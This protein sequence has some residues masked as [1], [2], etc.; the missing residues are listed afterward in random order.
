MVAAVLGQL[1]VLL[2]TA[3]LVAIGVRLAP[4][5]VGGVVRNHE[6]REYLA[7]FGPLAEFLTW[8]AFVA[9]A[10]M[11]LWTRKADDG[12]HVVVALL[13]ALLVLMFAGAWRVFR[14]YLAG[15]VLRTEAAWQVGDLIRV[16]EEEGTV[17]HL[18]HRTLQLQRPDGDLV[19]VPW[20]RISSDLLVRRHAEGDVVR[21]TFVVDCPENR[22]P[23]EVALRVEETVLLNHWCSAGHEP[24][25]KV[26]ADGSIQ[27]TVH[28]LT[29]ARIP[30]VEASVRSSLQ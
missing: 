21:H 11:W 9:G 7:R 25:I 17:A 1:M 24:A 14:D 23:S 28:A 3:V 5:L 22:S 6:R 16:G 29:E 19:H 15:V 26:R 4:L 30:E 27:V 18:G 2:L 8:V 20:S 13:A 12:I 10:G